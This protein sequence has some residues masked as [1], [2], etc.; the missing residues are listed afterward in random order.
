MYYA[1]I[2]ES[3]DR[4]WGGRSSQTFVLTAAIIH[5]SHTTSARSLMSHIRSDLG[6]PPTTVL[7]WSTNIK[8]H[9]QRKYVSAALGALDTMTVSSVVIHKPSF[10]GT[11]TGLSDHARMYNYA[12]RRLLERLSWFG[13]TAGEQVVPIFAHVKRFPYVRL[14]AYLDLLKRMPTE[15][16]WD[17]LSKVRIEQPQKIE[18]LQ[19]ADMCS[20]SVFAAVEPDAFDQY[21]ATYLLNIA[22]RLYRRGTAAITS[23]GL[24][25]CSSADHWTTYP[26]WPSLVGSL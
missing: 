13:R 2:D 14:I 8:V 16:K 11:G 17:N 6:K 3:G 5:R 26:W 24:N 7:H 12:V 23:Y 25:F 18:L 19:A 4:G 1:Y 21:E 15:I 20:G 10:M 9:T 22:P